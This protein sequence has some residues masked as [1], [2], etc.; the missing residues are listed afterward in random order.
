[1]LAN[2]Q[3]P[4]RDVEQELRPR[5]R[6]WVYKSPGRDGQNGNP[7]IKSISVDD[8][9]QEVGHQGLEKVDAVY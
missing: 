7:R 9:D 4:T 8:L 5:R 1:M 6:F 3:T 2:L